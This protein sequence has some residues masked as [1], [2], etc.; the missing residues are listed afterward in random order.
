MLTI[1]KYIIPKELDKRVKLTEVERKQILEL[2]KKGMS[3]RKLAA[4]FNVSRRLICFII[5]PA[6]KERCKEQFKERQKDGR[7]Y[8]TNK[9]T[10][11]TKKHRA[12]KKELLNKGLLIKKE[13]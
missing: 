1:D 7:Y 13:C 9:N 6:K 11:A 12:Y 4:K 3:Q 2:N 8:N 10:E 5:D